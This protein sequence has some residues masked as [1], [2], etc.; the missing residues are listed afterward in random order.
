M[1]TRFVGKRGASGA[2]LPTRASGAGQPGKYDP[3]SGI[4]I[5]RPRPQ[6]DDARVGKKPSNK[7]TP[8]LGV[9]GV[10]QSDL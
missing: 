10:G 2:H 6:T 4:F 1:A 3:N 7:K 9:G 8:S 5:P